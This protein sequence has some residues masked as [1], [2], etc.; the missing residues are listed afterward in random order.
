MESQEIH[1]APACSLEEEGTLVSQKGETV[2]PWEEEKAKF[3]AERQELKEKADRYLYLYAEFETFKK[4]VVKERSEWLKFGWEPLARELLQCVDNLERAL[5]H[6]PAELPP[7]FLEGVRQTLS[8][9]L[10]SL[11]KQ[12][13]QP[14]PTVGQPFNVEWHEAL[15]QVPSELPAG[16]IVQ[17][18]Q[19]GYTL[20]GRLLRPAQVQLSMGP[21]EKSAVPSSGVS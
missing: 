8:H 20:H 13:V 11:A 17:E 21:T 14:I 10:A 4:R 16:Q 6:A 19:K 3:E 7:A 15:S 9:F 18:F 2:S 5:Q 12:G 1:E